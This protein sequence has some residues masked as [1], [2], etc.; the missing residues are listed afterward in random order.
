MNQERSPG[1]GA[2]NGAGNAARQPPAVDARRIT[3]RPAGE[4]DF[5]GM[6]AIFRAVVA[7]GDTYVFAGDT[8]RDD[9][10]TYFLGPDITTRVAEVDGR[11]V[12]MYKLIANRRDRGAHVANASFMV[13]PW[14]SGR[15]IGRQLGTHCLREAK[16]AGFTAMQFNFV[17]STNTPAVALWQSL[18][19]RIV[20]TQPGVFRHATLGDVDAYVMHRSLDDIEGLPDDE[21]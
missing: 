5:E 10:Q 8:S 20:G 18:G 17:V 1:N 3:I 2:E 15:G 11:I 4:A 12:G 16:R 19:F 13:A 7:R 14:F 9:A 21:P 6:W